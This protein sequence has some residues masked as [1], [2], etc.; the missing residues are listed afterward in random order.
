[1]ANAG[2]QETFAPQPDLVFTMKIRDK[3]T[4]FGIYFLAPM[5][6]RL[7]CGRVDTGGKPHRARQTPH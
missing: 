6:K 1:M 3:A 2:M 5:A 7:L 4:N